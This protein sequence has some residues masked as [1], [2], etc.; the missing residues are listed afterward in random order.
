MQCTVEWITPDIAAEYLKR[1][2]ANRPLNK[3]HSDRCAQSML[4]GE[5]DMNGTPIRFDKS[6]NLLDGQHRLTAIITA[7][8]MVQMLVVRG[9]DTD[10]FKTIDVGGR[11][12]T[13]AD[14]LAIGGV[15]NANS[16]AAVAGQIHKL[17]T[18]GNPFAAAAYA[19]SAKQIEEMVYETPAIIEC[20]SYGIRHRSRL[21]SA[22]QV[23]FA[24]FC[25]IH[26]W[27]GDEA[28]VDA[29]FDGFLTGANLQPG[30]PIFMLRERL[31]ENLSSLRS[32]P[33]G[34]VVGLVFKAYRLHRDGRTVKQLKITTE[35]QSKEKDWFAPH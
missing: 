32:L 21:Y 31:I 25:F 3:Q 16:A 7:G 28:V 19:A 4:R 18:T 22:T 9:L 29:F 6:G 17:R 20:V 30:S 26:E 12:R 11:T 33:Q 8:V 23:A 2:V 27:G 35:G 13:T 5:W 34:V 10:V 15:K 1:N 24:R 14:V